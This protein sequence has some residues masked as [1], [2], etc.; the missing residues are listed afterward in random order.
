MSA[1]VPIV[2]IVEGHGEVQ[3]FPELLRRIAREIYGLE[4]DV[5]KPHRVARSSMTKGDLGRAVR[6]HSGRVARRGA[7]IVLADADDDD[8]EVLRGELQVLSDDAAPGAAV[9]VVAVREYEAWFLAGIESLRGHR[10]VRDDA[11][12]VSD[13]E[14]K[15]G[16]KEALSELMAE[17]YDPIRHQTAFSAIVD[18]ESACERSPSF[19]RLVEA[20]GG[21]LH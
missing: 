19:R 3:A 2:P 20:I 10:T 17:P 14:T 1:N 21:A 7:I 12:Y 9:V 16:C 13:P 4:I 8:P 18:I 15:R 11:V 5:Q 6:L